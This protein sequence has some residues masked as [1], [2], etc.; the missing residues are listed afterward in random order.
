M[1]LHGV[2]VLNETGIGFCRVEHPGEVREVGESLSGTVGTHG[3]GNFVGATG[4]SV[5]KRRIELLSTCEFARKRENVLF[6]G[7][8]G[9][10]KT[11]LAAGLGVRAI[12]NGFSV[13]YLTADDLIDRLRRDSTM[14]ARRRSKRRKYMRASVLIIDELGFQ[15]MTREDAHLLFKV[16]SYRYEKGSTI[17]T[18]NKSIRE[19][20]DMLA[21][22]EVLATA[23]LDRLLHHCNVVNIDG[24]SFRLRNIEQRIPAKE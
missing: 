20:P 1:H 6:L 21:G 9:V 22:D 10:G 14:T 3:E 19:W 12:Q 16:L 2:C 23:L 8:P 7:P 18:S 13:S 17:I 4:F 24:R 5:S 15:A 11:H